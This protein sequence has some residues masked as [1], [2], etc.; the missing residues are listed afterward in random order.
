[1][2]NGFYLSTY[3]SPPGISQL[4]N[5]EPR[6]DNNLSLWRL[7][8]KDLELVRHWELERLSG[9][10]QHGGAFRDVSDARSFI[11]S[12]LQEEGVNWPA[13]QASW[14]TPALDFGCAYGSPD[15]ELPTHG[16]AH[17]FSSLLLDSEIFHSERILCFAPDGGPDHVLGRTANWY[18]GGYVDRGQLLLFPIE[19]PGRLYDSASKRYGL[20]AGTLMAL[21]GACP[22]KL[23]IENN[24]DALV[25]T[26]DFR[27][28]GVIGGRPVDAVEDGN[29]VVLHLD[30][31]VRGALAPVSPVNGFSA[32]EVIIA[33]VMRLVQRAC[34]LVMERNVDRFLACTDLDPAGLHLGMAGGFALNCPSNVHLRTRYGFTSLVAP[35]CANDSGQALGLGLATFFQHEPD[36]RFHLGD[37]FKG[38]PARD[39]KIAAELFAADILSIEESLAR[40]AEDLNGGPVV[41]LA[42][43][44]EIGPRALGHRSLL[45]DPGRSPPRTGST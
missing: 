9:I 8:G 27:G 23:D 37:A 24:L 26:T 20:R 6:H 18:V 4:L 40:F 7:N 42:G 28:V 30:A 31:A 5:I 45:G 32:E 10:K 1:M 36:V 33:A 43:G 21:A 44:C 16:V 41:W 19:S 17:A 12:L 15:P 29:R 39:V 14:G 13:I 35:P 2:R 34:D 11:G 25:A 3:L 38:P 22:M